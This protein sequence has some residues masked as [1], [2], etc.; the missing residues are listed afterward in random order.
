MSPTVTATPIAD[1]ALPNG[2][3]RK[4]LAEEAQMVIPMLKDYEEKLHELSQRAYNIA[5]EYVQN[6]EG[7][8][9]V[10]HNA[11]PTKRI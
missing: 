7:H 3:P 10:R 4:P 2:L 8:W 5:T 11:D 9:V 1:A 6:K